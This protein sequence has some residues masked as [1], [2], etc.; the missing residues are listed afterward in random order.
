M[1][2]GNSAPSWPETFP[3]N[4]FILE[5]MASNCSTP[6][7]GSA[8]IL[9]LACPLLLYWE[10]N[11]SS[12]EGVTSSQL[13]SVLGRAGRR[14]VKDQPQARRAAEIAFREARSAAVIGVRQHTTS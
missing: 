3:T 2:H 7:T 11:W 12:W 1:H 4:I 13:S 9:P 10:S 6:P 8:P 5:T 14:A